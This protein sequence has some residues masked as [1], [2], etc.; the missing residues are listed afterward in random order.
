[1]ADQDAIAKLMEA[2]SEPEAAMICGFL[3]SRGIPATYDKGSV[4]AAPM[5][6]GGAMSGPFIG[7]QEIVVRA[8]DLEA[9]REALAELDTT[10]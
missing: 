2:S 8:K 9:A 10:P 1:M 7:Q 5:A 3:E 4:E 6:P